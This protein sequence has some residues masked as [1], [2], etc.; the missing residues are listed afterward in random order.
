MISETRWASSPILNPF[1]GAWLQVGNKSGNGRVRRLSSRYSQRHIDR[2][3]R[4][5]SRDKRRTARDTKRPFV[6]TLRSLFARLFVRRPCHESII[7]TLRA[8]PPS[9]RLPVFSD[10]ENPKNPAR[11]RW[12]AYASCLQ[13]L[14]GVANFARG[15]RLV[16]GNRKI[17]KYSIRLTIRLT[18]ER[19]F[20]FKIVSNNIS[21]QICQWVGLFVYL[22]FRRVYMY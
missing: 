17:R 8:P 20:Y 14:S 4:L 13:K 15:T 9:H 16:R 21:A 12:Q 2:R 5:C 7:R 10:E 19:N 3:L 6:Y 18:V 1:D 22:Y 11:C